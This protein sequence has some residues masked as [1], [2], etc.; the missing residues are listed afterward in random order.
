MNVPG[1]NVARLGMGG[2]VL[3]ADYVVSATFACSGMVERIYACGERRISNELEGVWRE[4]LPR[5][6]SS[7][8]Q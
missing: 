7:S 4:A 2:L 1:C 3:C 6:I 5:T 8:G